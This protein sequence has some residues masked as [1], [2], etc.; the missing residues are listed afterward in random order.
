MILQS[1]I[2]TGFHAGK[3]IPSQLSQATH[4]HTIQIPP[5]ALP[6]TDTAV[7]GYEQQG[8]FLAVVLVLI[9]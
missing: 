9:P 8:G 3:A 2:V 7:Q 1:H 5:S 6:D 4:R